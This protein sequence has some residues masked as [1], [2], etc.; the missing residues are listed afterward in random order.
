LEVEEM[1][2][3]KETDGGKEWEVMGRG[4]QWWWASFDASQSALSCWSICLIICLSVYLAIYLQW[5]TL[6]SISLSSVLWSGTLYVWF[7]V[8]DD[9]P[10]HGSKK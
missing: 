8:T 5:G 10:D 3:L 2:G 7:S 4:Q 9:L 1:G 6:N